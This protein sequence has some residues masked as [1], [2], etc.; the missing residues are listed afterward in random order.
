MERLQEKNYW[1]FWATILISLAIFIVFTVVQ[2]LGL[3]VYL[4]IH[5][6]NAV[7]ASLESDSKIG[8]RL[9]IQRYAFNG[10][11]ISMGQIPAAI[12]GISL[13]L[14]FASLRK[15]MSIKDYLGFYRPSFKSLFL[16][17]GVMILALISMQA[18]NVW[19]DRE[20]PEFMTEVY[21]STKNLPLLWIAVAIGAPLFEEILFRGFLLDG[22]KNSWLGTVGAV[23]VT[24]ASWAIIHM[25]Y[26]WFE[27]TTIFILGVLFA[28][29][30]IKTGSIYVPIALH[31]M[32]NITA[33][34][35]MELSKNQ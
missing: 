18:I 7:Q 4:Y 31:M 33:S 19:L 8:I 14:L 16:F 15:P 24:S 29:S 6:T 35:G 25:Q 10:D 1:G 28:I 12:I 11:A 21:S 13:V 27:I 23:I 5:E 9:L 22:L 20:T 32:M 3:V 34:I 30:K 26:G 17:F 2:T